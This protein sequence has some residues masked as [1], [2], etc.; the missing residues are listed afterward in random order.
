MRILNGCIETLQNDAVI[1]DTIQEYLKLLM[2]TDG[3][4]ALI[5]NP[6]LNQ[7]NYEKVIYLHSLDI[8]KAF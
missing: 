6:Y 8:F 1:K 7:F 3:T 2:A 4:S 5:C